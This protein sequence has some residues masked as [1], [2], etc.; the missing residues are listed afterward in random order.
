MKE[1]SLTTRTEVGSTSFSMTSD[2]YAGI[3]ITEFNSADAAKKR[4]EC[5]DKTGSHYNDGKEYKVIDY[6]A[7]VHLWLYDKYIIQ[8]CSSEGAE[9]SALVGVFGSEFAGA[10]D[11]YGDNSPIQPADTYAS[12]QTVMENHDVEYKKEDVTPDSG[13]QG[14]IGALSANRLHYFRRRRLYSL[15]L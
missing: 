12:I 13:N 9:Y 5:Y 8:Y 7:P 15:R 4:S 10:G 11:C 3:Y 2:P 6:I 1:Q 14:G